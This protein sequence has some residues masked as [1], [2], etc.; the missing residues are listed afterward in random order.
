MGCRS[1][2]STGA[3]IALVTAG[4]ILGFAAPATFIQGLNLR[5]VGVIVM[6]A[7]V[8]PCCYRCWSGVR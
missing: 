5:V 4:A 6:L 8:V 2:M 7:G 3:G 1:V